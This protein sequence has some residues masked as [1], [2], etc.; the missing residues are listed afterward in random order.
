MKGVVFTTLND[1]VEDRFGLATWDELLERSGSSG[2]YTSA[3]TYPDQELFTLVG[4][5]SELLQ[6]DA[7]KLVR[8]FGEFMFNKLAAHY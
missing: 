4:G 1:L 8:T 5:L 3:G 6:V 7:D 2:V